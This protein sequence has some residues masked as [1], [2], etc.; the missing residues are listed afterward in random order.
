MCPQILIASPSKYRQEWYRTELDNYG[1]QAL[2]VE[3]GVECISALRTM[4]PPDALILE[5]SI[6][7]GGIDNV[8]IA[9]DE[10]PQL[11]QIPVAI[12]AVDGVSTEEYHLAR[13]P[14]Q[15]FFSRVPSAKDLATALVQSFRNANNY[16]IDSMNQPNDFIVASGE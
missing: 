2:I 9:M 10:H 4:P 5:S 15:V 14:I 11:R 6:R 16:P 1:L 8:L 3:N 7:W 13:F 12:I